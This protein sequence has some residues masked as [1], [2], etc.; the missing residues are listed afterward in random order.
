MN[1]PILKGTVSVISSDLTFIEGMSDSKG[2]PV[3]IYPDNDEVA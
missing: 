3:N 2:Y 1:I